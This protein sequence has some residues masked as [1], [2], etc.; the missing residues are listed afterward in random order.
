[1]QSRR[2]DEENSSD[3]APVVDQRLGA[4]SRFTRRFAPRSAKNAKRMQAT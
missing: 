2:A 3:R 4:R 1:M